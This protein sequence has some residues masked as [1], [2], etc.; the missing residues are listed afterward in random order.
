[1]TRN[2]SGLIAAL[3]LAVSVAATPAAAQ[4]RSTVLITG[5]STV[6]PFTK[7]VA[8]ALAQRGGPPAEIRVTGTVRGFADFCQGSALRYA[9]LSNASRR[10][11]GTEFGVCSSRGVHEVMEIPI[12]FDGIVITHRQGLPPVSLK[13]EHIW[14]A[15][16]RDIPREGR[17][18]AN[19]YT[20]WNQIAPDLP[21]WPI[22]VI[23][24][25]PTSG[26]RDSFTELAL[27][28]GCQALAPVRALPVPQQRRVCDTVREDGAW[29]D[30][31]EDDDAIA[32]RIEESEPGTLGIFG[33]SFLV[34]HGARLGAVAVEGVAP[35]REAISADR[36]PLARP[37]FLYVKRPNLEQVPALKAFLDEYLSDA[38]MGAE[39]YLVRGG[40][41]PLE[42]GRLRLVRDAV[43]KGAIMLRR[44]EN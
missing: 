39:G 15:V 20:H 13:L 8:N 19:P 10:I 22:R 21:A 40:L 34:G 36:Y 26:T 24:P 11:N 38:A 12:G 9:D 41:V 7:A 1:M 23:G 6:A 18:I 43:A 31:G 2:A 35:T 37:L 44:P 28:V 16:A 27:R 25:P 4:Q 3:C 42:P 29:I 30:G 14:R 33:Y 17:L 32:R 5:S